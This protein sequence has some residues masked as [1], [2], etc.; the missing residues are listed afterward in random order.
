MPPITKR[1]MF[2]TPEADAILWLLR[3]STRQSVEPGHLKL[4]RV[5]KIKKMIALIEAEKPLRCNMDTASILVPPDQKKVDVALT[6]YAR[7]SDHVPFPVPDH[8]L[9]EG[10]PSE[11]V[12]RRKLP[13]RKYS[14]TTT[15]KWRIGRL[16][17]RSHEPDAV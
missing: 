3:F 13:G 4:A 17:G 11:D 10:W 8:T 9:I 14:E 2:D 12:G 5:S 15:K 6:E 1:A 7:E 16:R